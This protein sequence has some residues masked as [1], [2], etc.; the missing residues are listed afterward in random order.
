M[1]FR[2][3]DYDKLATKYDKNKK[4]ISELNDENDCI[5]FD[6]NCL[7]SKNS[8]LKKVV[9]SYSLLSNDLI[10]LRKTLVAQ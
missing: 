3:L 2:S 10:N 8:E 7:K 1:L 4:L 6:N 9:S 5:L